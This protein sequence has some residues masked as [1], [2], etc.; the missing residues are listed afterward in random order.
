MKYRALRTIAFLYKMLAI[1]VVALGFLMFYTSAQTSHAL[2]SSDTP[3]SESASLA[4]G[5]TTLISLGTFVGTLTI[6]LFLWGA[7]DLVHVMLA[8]EENTRVWP[9]ALAQRA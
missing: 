8:I 3:P 6:A 1:L 7:A 2:M 4:V 5:F 9:A